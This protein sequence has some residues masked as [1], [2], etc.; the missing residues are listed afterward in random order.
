M[1]PRRPDRKSDFDDFV[2]GHLASLTGF[3]RLLAGD[4]AAGLVQ[5]ALPVR[6]CGGVAR[7]GKG[8]SSR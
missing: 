6:T 2:R 4:D 3:G 1:A 8:G 5:E 7:T